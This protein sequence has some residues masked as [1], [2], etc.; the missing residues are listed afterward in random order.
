[1]RGP[2]K[3][4]LSTKRFQDNCNW[5]IDLRVKFKWVT[6]Y[7][8]RHFKSKKQTMAVVGVNKTVV[9]AIT[10]ELGSGW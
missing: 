5:L 6:S 8:E 4:V 3:L 9:I 2:P 10:D 7:V 1:M